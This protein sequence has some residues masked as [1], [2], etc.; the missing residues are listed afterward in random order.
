MINQ[1]TNL[2]AVKIRMNNDN[3]IAPTDSPKYKWSLFVSLEN[4]SFIAFSVFFRRFRV[5]TLQERMRQR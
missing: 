5:L 4:L 1:I 3:A 2:Q